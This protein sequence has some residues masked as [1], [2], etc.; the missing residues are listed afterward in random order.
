MHSSAKQII[1]NE[2]FPSESSEIGEGE[3]Y[4]WFGSYNDMHV[5]FQRMHRLLSETERIRSEKYHFQN[6]RHR[7]ILRRGMLRTMI[8][9]YLSADPK[10][11][12]F[13]TNQ[14]G[15]PF[16]ENQDHEGSLEFNQSYSEEMVVYTFSHNRR[17]GI[18]IEYMKPIK[19]MN[20]IVESNFSP[21]EKAEFNALPAN[22]RLEA[23]YR[24]WTEKEAF[25]KALGDGL[26]RRLDQFD[27]SMMPGAPA[28]LKRTVWDQEEAG[29][30]SLASIHFVSGYAA[31]LAVEGPG[32]VLRYRQLTPQ[33]YLFQHC[34]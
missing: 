2:M 14:Y 25:L 3:V 17:V 18:D 10:E 12:R 28:A 5:D 23:F 30:W 8:G 9:H 11:I 22:Q 15:K 4:L 34:S 31:A 24:C 7:F 27:V 6:D 1:M 21:H 33:L 19:D 20:A 29:R 16:I 26:S 13:G 32:R